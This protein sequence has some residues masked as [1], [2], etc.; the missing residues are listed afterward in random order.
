[1]LRVSELSVSVD[2]EIVVDHYVPLTITWEALS[3]VSPVYWRSGDL[4]HSFVEIGVDPRSGNLLS[5]TMTLA[6]PE[7]ELTTISAPD[8]SGAVEVGTRFA[9]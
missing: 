1:M 6:G 4:K 8:S 5:I 7:V 3:P 2:S 9:T